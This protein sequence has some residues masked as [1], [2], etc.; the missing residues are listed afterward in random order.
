MKVSDKQ[1][2]QCHQILPIDDDEQVLAIYRHHIFAYIVPALAATLVIAVLMGL[3]SLMTTPT[4]LGGSA[5]IPVEYQKI[6]I[7]AAII[8]SAATAVFMLVP[9]WLRAQEHIVLTNEAILQVLQPALFASKVSQTSLD[10]IADVSVRQDFLGTILGYGKLTVETPGEQDNYEYVY[11]PNPKEAAR[12][13]IEAQENFV[14]ALQSGSLP[15]KCGNAA[16]SEVNQS[17]NVSVSA[18]EYRAFQEFQRFQKQ[19]K[20]TSEQSDNNTQA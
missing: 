11:L 14:A 17:K 2:Q 19:Q 8:L 6:T 10:H 16:H 5:I 7:G 4:S 3:A 13:I 9:I 15:S 18:E 1:N 20:Q 12:E